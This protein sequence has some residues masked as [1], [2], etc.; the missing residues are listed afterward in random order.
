MHKFAMA[1]FSLITLII[2]DT[3]ARSVE[4]KRRVGQDWKEFQHQHCQ[5]RMGHSCKKVPKDEGKTPPRTGE[6]MALEVGLGVL[7]GGPSPQPKGFA[8]SIGKPSGGVLIK[9]P[10][11]LS[12]PRTHIN[13]ESTPLISASARPKAQGGLKR[14]NGKIGYLLGDPNAPNLGEEPAAKQVRIDRP[15]SDLESDLD[16]DLD[17]ELD[18][19]SLNI[20][21]SDLSSIKESD[22]EDDN[23][24]AAEKS[25]FSLIHLRGPIQESDIGT[26]IEE[27]ESIYGKDFWLD[28]QLDIHTE[29]EEYNTLSTNDKINF[30]DYFALRNYTEDSYVKIN[31]AMHNNDISPKIEI[32]IAQLTKAL[33]RNSDINLSLRNRALKHLDID[34]IDIVYRGEVRNKSEF[35]AEMLE[36]EVYSNDAFFS[37]T[38]DAEYIANFQTENLADGEVNISYSIHYPKGL[39][40]STDIS[41][42]LGNNEGT[43]IFPPNSHFLI[44]EVKPIDNDTIEIEMRYLCSSPCI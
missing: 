37:T 34:E 31:N 26:A 28:T 41:T 5:W 14:V 42:L 13:S 3:Y 23:Q 9:T 43:R 44:T 11:T 12:T 8:F 18:F 25:K 1:F 16:L 10:I 32:E 38:S 6:E 4:P 36:E 30:Q 7:A 21:E 17:L 19:D 22:T 27:M 40:N 33:K 15:E 39:T 2:N 24:L 35:K 29:I 20:N